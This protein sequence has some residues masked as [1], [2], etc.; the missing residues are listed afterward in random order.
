MKRTMVHMTITSM[1]LLLLAVGCR[2]MTG[3]SLG[4]NVDNQTTTASVKARLI[5]DQLQNL[6]WVDVDTNAGTVYLSGTAATEAQKTRAAEIARDVDG[7]RGVVNNIQVRSSAAPGSRPTDGQA[8]TT[9]AVSASPTTASTSGSGTMVGEVVN[10]DHGTGRLTLR[11][12]EGDMML[13]FPPAAVAGVQHGDRVRVELVR[14]G[15]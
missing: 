10:V 15:Q 4:T 9:A 6:T 1:V 8:G 11:T 13:H 7:V 12:G 14:R 5:A 3:Q 2:S